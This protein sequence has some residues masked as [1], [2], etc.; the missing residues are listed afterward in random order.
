[1]FRLSASNEKSTDWVQKA[2]DETLA[3]NVKTTK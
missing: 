3:P 1:M 2:V